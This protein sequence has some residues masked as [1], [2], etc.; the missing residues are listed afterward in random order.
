MKNFLAKFGSRKF[1]LTIAGL[2]GVT[3]YPQYANDIV[4]L[5][6]LYLGAE[7]AADTVRAYSQQKYV[8]PQKAVAESFFNSADDEDDVDKD[9]EPVPGR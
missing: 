7:G 1:L 8:E 4:T 2:L 6:G 3:A 5:I 9:S